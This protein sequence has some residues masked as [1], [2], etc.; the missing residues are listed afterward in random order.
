MIRHSSRK[1]GR[2]CQHPRPEGE[3]GFTASADSAVSDER[4]TTSGT[5][6]T[7]ESWRVLFVA[8]I[9]RQ[10]AQTMAIRKNT[11]T[12][13]FQHAHGSPRNGAHGFSQGYT[14]TAVFSPTS[15]RSASH[16]QTTQHDE[17][18]PQA[19]M[20]KNMV[21]LRH[22]SNRRGFGSRSPPRRQQ[23][24]KSRY[25]C[26]DD[27]LAR[28]TSRGQ[29]VQPPSKANDPRVG[30]GGVSDREAMWDCTRLLTHTGSELQPV[31]S[32]NILRLPLTRQRVSPTRL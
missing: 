14:Q 30:G 32:R 3:C 15:P 1:D 27:A 24:Q 13:T 4:S 28:S 18:L 21:A 29:V 9:T 26:Q 2:P 23:R 7:E 22:S 19:L 12:Q 8:F 6:A 11:P 25:G 20:K 16:H 10:R 31:P 5:H 17:L